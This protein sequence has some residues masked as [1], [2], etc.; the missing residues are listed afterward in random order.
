MRSGHLQTP[1]KRLLRR[2][3]RH[4]AAVLLSGVLQVNKKGAWAHGDNV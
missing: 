3:K 4:T 1:K 2:K